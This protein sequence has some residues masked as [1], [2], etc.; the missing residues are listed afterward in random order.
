MTKFLLKT[1][2][3][4]SAVLGAALDSPAAKSADE[5]NPPPKSALQQQLDSLDKQRQS[6]RRQLGEKVDAASV[7]IADFIDKLPLLSQADCPALDA[8][9]IDG[10]I[11]AAAKKQALQPA[12]LHAM[13]KQESAFKPCAISTKGAQGLMQIMPAT[14]QQFHVSDPFDPEQN[15]E[16]G[17]AFM[18]ELLTRYQGDLRLALVAYN[19]GPGRADQP[20]AVPFPLETQNYVASVFAE[21]GISRL[22]SELLPEELLPEKDKP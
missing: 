2:L 12:L 17:A 6:I 21:L 19:A 7:P 9:A 18:K 8:P 1:I 11:A 3:L 13:M 14:A 20:D 22:Q 16:A 5:K 4:L 15:V 10:L